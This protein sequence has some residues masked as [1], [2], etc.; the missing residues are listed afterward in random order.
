VFDNECN[1]LPTAGLPLAETDFFERPSQKLALSEFVDSITDAEHDIDE[2][3][4][5]LPGFLNMFSGLNDA[6]VQAFPLW[7]G[8]SSAVLFK[9]M[10]APRTVLQLVIVYVKMIIALVLHDRTVKS[11]LTPD[12]MG[13]RVLHDCVKHGKFSLYQLFDVCLMGRIG[14]DLMLQTMLVH[15]VFVPQQSGPLHFKLLE[16]KFVISGRLKQHTYDMHAMRKN[17]SNYRADIDFYPAEK[18]LNSRGGSAVTS[19]PTLRPE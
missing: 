7:A 12:T 6:Q 9:G 1:V 10:H 5:I 3:E 14:P 8:E 16:S 18:T 2:N 4:L 19:G 11:D 17:A 13:Q 15:Q